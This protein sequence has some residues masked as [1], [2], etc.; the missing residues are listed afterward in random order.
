MKPRV[1]HCWECHP[2]GGATC[3]LP[4]DHAG[5]HEFTPDREIGITFEPPAGDK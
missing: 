4:L 3:M 5:E 1:L 2:E